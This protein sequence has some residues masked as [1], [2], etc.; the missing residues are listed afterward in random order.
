MET[1]A[2]YTD[3]FLGEEGTGHVTLELE[4]QVVVWFLMWVL[5]TEPWLSARTLSVLITEASY[6]SADATPNSCKL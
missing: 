6:L 1:C 2:P 4:K 5:G 3:T